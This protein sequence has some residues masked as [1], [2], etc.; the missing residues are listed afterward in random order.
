M[1]KAPGL[2]LRSLLLRNS[3]A[4]STYRTL[5]SCL[6]TTERRCSP[7]RDSQAS[8]N[9][10]LPSPLRPSPRLPSSQH[11]EF[12]TLQT[13][14]H[15]HA[16]E[17]AAVAA[18]RRNQQRGNRHHR[19]CRLVIAQVHHHPVPGGPQSCAQYIAAINYAC[20]QHQVGESTCIR[21]RAACSDGVTAAAR[22]S[23]PHEI[24]QETHTQ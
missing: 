6:R 24:E 19:T 11:Q 20:K 22:R 4:A 1:K 14:I 17:W 8:R 16:V 21:Q 15:A 7:W 18:T 2:W 12:S 10:R 9:T 13:C 5:P 23:G 3:L